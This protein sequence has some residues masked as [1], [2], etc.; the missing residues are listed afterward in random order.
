MKW[1]SQWKKC[2]CV[3]LNPEQHF[4]SSFI[5]VYLTSI[6]VAWGQRGVKE[7]LVLRLL[8]LALSLGLCLRPCLWRLLGLRLHSSCRQIGWRGWRW[9]VVPAKFCCLT[10]T[11]TQMDIYEIGSRHNA[12][13]N[14][15]LTSRFVSALPE[16]GLL[17]KPSLPGIVVVVPG[18][19]TP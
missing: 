16:Y 4:A 13:S 7:G 15:N 6:S 9:R 3:I 5:Q 8:T 10:C 14:N 1:C 11:D 17:P 18:N 19:V 12:P 2:S